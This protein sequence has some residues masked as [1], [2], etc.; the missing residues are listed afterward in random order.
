MIHFAR[1]LEPHEILFI[2]VQIVSREVFSISIGTWFDTQ[3]ILLSLLWHCNIRW[4][5]TEG[6]E[7]ARTMVYIVRTYR[8]CKYK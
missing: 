2:P 1:C 5:Y 3:H 7:I 8:F 6:A 4:A